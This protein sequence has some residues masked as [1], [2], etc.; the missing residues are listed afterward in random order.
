ML[1]NLDELVFLDDGLRG[2]HSSWVRDQVTHEW[3]V[4]NLLLGWDVT[5]QETRM[6]NHLPQK[7]CHE[8][9]KTHHENMGSDGGEE[10]GRSVAA[11]V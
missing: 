10:V 11:E 1:A 3:Q 6:V 8:V 7:W 9:N 2:T 5:P 4:M